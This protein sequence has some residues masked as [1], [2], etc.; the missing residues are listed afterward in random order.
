MFTL[1]NI[2]LGY[3]KIFT[4]LIKKKKI[5]GFKLTIVGNRNSD[6]IFLKFLWKT[7]PRIPGAPTTSTMILYK[8]I[9][10]FSFFKKSLGNLAKMYYLM[11]LCKKIKNI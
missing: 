1:L 3:T 8:H 11:K 10:E 7:F 6:A 5:S 9:Y 2:T 4:C